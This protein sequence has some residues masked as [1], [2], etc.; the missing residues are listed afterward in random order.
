MS[1][2]AAHFIP[3]NKF[4]NYCII[5][6]E[7][8]FFFSHQKKHSENV[9]LWLQTIRVAFLFVELCMCSIQADIN[10]S[11]SCHQFNCRPLS[12]WYPHLY[13]VLPLLLLFVSS[14]SF[15]IVR[16]ML[17][18]EPVYCVSSYKVARQTNQIQWTNEK[19]L[20]F[21]FVRVS[22]AISRLKSLLLL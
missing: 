11:S 1:A 6:D 19:H 14:D 2:C 9:W 7:D 3:G 20:H 22:I 21:S 5:G 15:L 8:E 18:F 10:R 4:S 13:L 12:E 16:I 17:Y